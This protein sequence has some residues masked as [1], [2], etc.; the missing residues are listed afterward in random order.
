MH[1]KSIERCQQV[2]TLPMKHSFAVNGQHSL[3]LRSAQFPSFRAGAL[4]GA[5]WRRI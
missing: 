4:S 1:I 3:H 5:E 2:A